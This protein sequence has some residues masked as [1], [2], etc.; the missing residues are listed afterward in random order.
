MALYGTVPPFQ[1]PGITLTRQRL[2]EVWIGVI[3]WSSLQVDMNHWLA[4]A[5]SGL[6]VNK[7][8]DGWIDDHPPILVFKELSDHDTQG[9]LPTNSHVS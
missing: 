8:P 6:M 5:G 2:V 4:V 3:G 9:Y 7:T 1:D